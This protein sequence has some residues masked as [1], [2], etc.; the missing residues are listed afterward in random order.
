MQLLFNGGGSW[1][2]VHR[3]RA[4]VPPFPTKPTT[5]AGWS[6][7]PLGSVPARIGAPLPA[8]PPAEPACPSGRQTQ[9]RKRRTRPTYVESSRPEAS[10]QSPSSTPHQRQIKLRAASCLDQPPASA[11]LGRL[12]E[13]SGQPARPASFPHGRP[14]AVGLDLAPTRERDHRL[15]RRAGEAAR[16]HHSDPAEASPGEGQTRARARAQQDQ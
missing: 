10:A 8:R 14:R 1:F 6:A 7:A 5:A 13:G 12:V 9:R 4:R 11:S 3:L 2:I 15:G 16:L